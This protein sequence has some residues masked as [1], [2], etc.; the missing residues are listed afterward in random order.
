MI[1]GSI[2]LNEKLTAIIIIGSLIT[3]T[4][5]YLVNFSM[6]KIREKELAG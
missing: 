1:T 4:G 3:L 6:K 2:L 5:V